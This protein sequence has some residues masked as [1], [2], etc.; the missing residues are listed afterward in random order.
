M[1]ARFQLARASSFL[2]IKKDKKKLYVANRC[3]LKLI[4]NPV[5]YSNTKKKKKKKQIRGRYHF[6]KEA[7]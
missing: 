5:F 3:G 6:V 2:N 7:D 4:E 1:R